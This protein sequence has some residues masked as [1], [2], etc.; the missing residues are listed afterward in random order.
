MENT[1]LEPRPGRLVKLD[2][3]TYPIWV[4]DG[5]EYEHALV[6]K[7]IDFSFH[8]LRFPSGYGAFD[9]IVYADWQLDLIIR[10]LLGVIDKETQQRICRILFFLS[11]RGNGK[12]TLAAAIGL[13]FLTSMGEPSPEVDLFALNR[14]QA[15]RMF[16]TAQTMVVNSRYLDDRLQIHRTEKKILYDATNGEMAVRSGDADS[17]LGLNPS[18]ALIDELLAQKNRALFAAVVTALGKRPGSTLMT[19]TTPSKRVESFAKTE[20]KRAAEIMSDRTLDYSYVPVIFET[21]KKNDPPGELETWIKANP[22]ITSGFLN[23]NVL[24]QEWKA[25]EKDPQ[26][27]VDFEV[28]RLAQWQD[29]GHGFFNMREWDG[30]RREM[31][32]IDYL[33]GLPCY[34]GL[35]MSALSDLT[36]MSILFVDDGHEWALWRHWTTQSALK[37][38]NEWTA[39]AFQQWIES[40]VVNCE[41]FDG[42]WIETGEVV[43]RM[44][45]DFQIF[46][47]VEIGMDQYRCREMYRHLGPKGANL[48][49]QLLSQTG[50]M[51]QA[52]T[53]R[54]GNSVAANRLFHNGDPLARWAA[55]N[56]KVIYTNEEYPKLVK[57]DPT[58]SECR[59]DPIDA[60]NMCYD[61]WIADE[62]KDLEEEELPSGVV[63]LSNR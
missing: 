57:G 27:M 58:E 2:D 55:S 43:D 60:V 46:E 35:D 25:A 26:A 13:F 61:R 38:L 8:Y 19:M 50:R 11:A 62:L 45:E 23:P 20:Y 21:D 47:P 30:N 4:P 48:P 34:F 7:F 40:P 24:A 18:L 52:A 10:P 51:M 53:E 56:T 42:D 15:Q 41:V 44:L 33:R 12:T 17:E 28:F 63:S 36:S 5:C 54:L 49:C 6:Q 37:S 9:P 59:I 16:K 29:A 22:A 3:A 1:L 39:N 32:P 14:P 31:P